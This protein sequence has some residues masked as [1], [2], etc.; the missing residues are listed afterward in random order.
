MKNLLVALALAVAAGAHA[1]P[2]AP[3]AVEGPWARAVL[4]GQVSSGAYMTFVA[5]EPVTLLGAA[6]PAAGIVEIHEMKLEGDF[7]KM[8]AVDRLELA[9]GQRVEFKPGGYHF[10]LMDLKAKLNPG[11]TLPL[12]LQFRDVGGKLREVQ[13][14]LPVAAA[15][16]AS[17]KH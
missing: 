3:V 12:T 11:M 8:R 7:M 15:A 6:S 2:A 5:R 10:M 16:P 1:Q 17:H 13:V 4:P 14:S 9:A